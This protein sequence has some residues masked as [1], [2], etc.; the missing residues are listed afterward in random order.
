MA[1][2]ALA[3][4]AG[5]APADWKQQTAVSFKEATTHHAALLIAISPGI[6]KLV[7]AVR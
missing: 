6:Q 7:D 3:Y 4:A 2:I 1:R 5:G